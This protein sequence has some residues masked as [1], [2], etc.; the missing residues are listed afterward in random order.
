MDKYTV[1]RTIG[2]GSYGT[3]YQAC[4]KNS[5][6]V[7]ALKVITK[8]KKNQKDIQNLRQEFEIQRTL[9]HPNIIRM[10]D[11]FETDHDI[12]VVTEFAP[13][14][15]SLKLKEKGQLSEESVKSVVCDLLSALYYLH[16]HRVL[17]RDLKPQNIL[18]EANGTAKLCDFGFARSMSIDTYVL[19]SIKGTP[20]YM[21][22]E[23]IDGCPY[24]HSADLW[25][26]GCIVYECL[27]GSPPFYT[28]ALLRLVNLIQ[29]EIKWPMSVSPD[30]LS[31]LR[32]LLEKDPSKRL[33]W[34]DLLH[35]PFV[36]FS[37]I[38]L[39]NVPSNA[40]VVVP[41]THPLTAS[42]ALAKEKQKKDLICHLAGKPR[43][44]AESAKYLE[45][46]E[47]KHKVL[48]ELQS[49]PKTRVCM[50]SPEC[51]ENQTLGNNGTCPMMYAVGHKTQNDAVIPMQ[52]TPEKKLAFPGVT[53]LKA[54]AGVQTFD[55]KS[56]RN[57]EIV[58]TLDSDNVGD[59][60]KNTIEH[61]SPVP[62]SQVEHSNL[63]TTKTDKF[64]GQTFLSWISDDNP[65]P[66]ECE[67]WLVFLQKTMEEVM[68]GEVDMMKQE[69]FIAMLVSH[70]RNPHASSKVVEY[71][72]CLLSLPF[73][74]NGV[75][76]DALTRIKEVY[77]VVKVVP[78]L[79]YASNLLTQH[80]MTDNKP[81]VEETDSDLGADELQAI[82][83]IY[84]LLCHLTHLSIDFLTQFCDAV[85]IFN[86][87]ALLRQLLLLG[88]RKARIVADL[89]AILAHILRVLPESALIVEQIALGSVE[90]EK[91][92]GLS[93]ILKNKTCP[94]L[95]S[96]CCHLLRQLGKCSCRALQNAWSPG[97][98]S[99]LE[100]LLNDSSDLVS[101]AAEE[102]VSKLKCLVFYEA[103]S[104]PKR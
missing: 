56:D 99:A 71:V 50:A 79:V 36:D 44:Y 35:H 101:K 93:S 73:V 103:Q 95:R 24:D 40:A 47:N 87:V 18:V 64:D 66:I 2:Q 59:K 60:D 81:D 78:N 94:L 20:L 54:E 37:K 70:L 97:L 8:H 21:A 15:L 53:L 72:A 13:Q 3:V 84:L 25:S 96:R 62:T 1:I 14:D 90:G 4:S 6:Q 57:S 41:L 51:A 19:V 85:A 61:L 67:E 92:K 26:L 104:R 45:Q 74:V 100:S 5:D 52:N 42:Q 83:C 69:N 55:H 49:H 23:I 102:A 22:P 11:S 39:G 30:C 98:R 82:E 7:V 76:D 43:S 27:V 9:C 80:K 16:Y 33:S 38:N 63:S 29:G 68:D 32:G 88:R 10:L 46:Q 28:N 31:F 48:Q 77:L 17:H 86:C 34:P 91:G 12:I 65:Q 58:P 89:L 75:N